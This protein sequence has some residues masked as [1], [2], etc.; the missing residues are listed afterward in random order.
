[1]GMIRILCIVAGMCL[2]AASTVSGGIL[3]AGTA[4]DGPWQMT[5]DKLSYNP[6]EAEYVA[7]GNVVIIHSNTRLQ[8]DHVR[9]RSADM[10]AYASGNVFFQVENDTLTG[11]HVVVDLTTETGTVYEGLLFVEE[12]NFYISGAR[13]IKTGETTYS[14]NQA[15]LTTCD[16]TV[17]D[18]SITGSNVNVTVEGY[19]T[20]T[21]A[22]FRVRDIPVF[23]VPF[24]V[25]PAKTQRQSGLLFPYFEYSSKNGFGYIQPYFWAISDHLDAT[26][27]YHHIQN[28]GEKLGLEYR[29][30]RSE[31]SK[32]TVM[33]DGFEDRQVDDDPNDPN[34]KWG[35]TDD[36]LLRPNSGRYWFRMKADQEL[37]ADITARVDLDIVSDQDYLRDFNHGYTGYRHS[38]NYF[39]SEFDRGID[40]RNDRMRENRINLNRTWTT[41]SLNADVLWYDNVVARR[42]GDVN[43]TLQRLPMV[44]YNFLKQ[45]LPYSRLY[46]AVNTEY[47]YFFREDGV[48]GHRADLYPRVSLPFY[49]AGIFTFEPSV[50]Y[51]QTVWYLDS[52]RED[53]RDDWRVDSNI[54]RYSQRGMFDL[55]ADLSADINR[56][57]PVS[58][59]GVE[60]IKHGILPQVSYA[61]IPAVNQSEFPNF[62]DIDRIP[63]QNQMLFSLTHFLTS[64]RTVTPPNADPRTVYKLF[65]R[66]LI[67]QPYDF[68]YE[69]RDE[70]LLPLYSELEL[71]P[72]RMLRLYADTQYSH[73]ENTFIAGNTSVRLRDLLGADFRV[74]YRYTKDINKTLYFQLSVP[75]RTWLDVYGDYERSLITNTDVELNAGFRYK[76]GCWSTD[77]TYRAMQ[78]LEGTRDDSFHVQVHLYGLGEFGN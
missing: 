40:E 7:E 42:Q 57:F 48:T 41:S 5:A 1:M 44:N 76:A 54:S 17:P 58:S 63:R 8:A 24:F 32:G 75:L 51:R 3:P 35:Y 14:I 18:W 61:Y 46:G 52:N 15:K 6:A 73:Q 2:L 77:F 62:D 34:R 56:V 23:Y 66:F 67:E 71:T 27:Y 19:A 22:A 55:G 65:A 38:L 78:D 13:I 72:A 33:I 50:G 43:N 39:E 30:M 9:F 68:N 70:A 64:R 37:P 49:P 26:F 21:N 69:E 59:F 60:A 11:D 10:T 20:V 74:D 36:S 4:P 53:I 16:E 31:L 28:R 12:T 47:T 25:F 45:P 29:Y